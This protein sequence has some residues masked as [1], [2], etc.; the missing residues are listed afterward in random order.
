MLQVF[1]SLPLRMQECFEKQDIPML[2]QV[3]VVSAPSLFNYYTTEEE[4]SSDAGFRVRY[5]QNK[6]RT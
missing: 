6:N 5:Y 4:P 3:G 2:Q 1:E